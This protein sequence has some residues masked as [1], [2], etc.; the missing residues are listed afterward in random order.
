[1]NKLRGLFNVFEQKTEL[2]QLLDAGRHAPGVHIL[3]AKN[4]AWPSWTNAA[5]SS[6]RTQRTARSIGTLAVIG[7]KRMSYDRVVPIVD[8]TAKLLSNALSQQHFNQR[9]C[10]Y[11]TNRHTP[12]ARPKRPA[13]CWSTSARLMLRP[14]KRSIPYLKEFLGDPRV[15]EIPRLIWWF[16]LNGIIL[17]INVPKIGGQCQRVDAKAPTLKVHRTPLHTAARLPG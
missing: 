15:V 2:L 10:A 6:R 16:I 7:P 9:P 1:M 12:T 13:F 8:I 4:Q 11:Q 14:R 17:N 5:W 3:S